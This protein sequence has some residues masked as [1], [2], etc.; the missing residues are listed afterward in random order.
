[1]E[2]RSRKREERRDRIREM[3]EGKSAFSIGRLLSQITWRLVTHTQTHPDHN[4]MFIHSGKQIFQLAL[5]S[6]D[7][8]SRTLAGASQRQLLH[9]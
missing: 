4:R 8:S 6:S 1:M 9:P 7:T 3:M 2:G 5:L